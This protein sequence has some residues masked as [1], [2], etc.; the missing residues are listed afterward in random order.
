M[1]MDGAD[2]LAPSIVFT[3][4]ELSITQLVIN[5]MS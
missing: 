1:A 5:R 3:N 4:F 2:V